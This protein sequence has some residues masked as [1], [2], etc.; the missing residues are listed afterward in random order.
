MSIFSTLRMYLHRTPKLAERSDIYAHHVTPLDGR[1]IHIVAA[2]APDLNAG[3]VR[4][5][6][7]DT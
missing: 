1:S 5:G 6:R 3:A 2:G 7:C 4:V